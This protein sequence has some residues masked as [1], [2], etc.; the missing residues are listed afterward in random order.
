MCSIKD[1]IACQL[2]AIE[3]LSEG[4]PRIAQLLID[5]RENLVAI[6]FR[7]IIIKFETALDRAPYPN[8]LVQE[9]SKE[10]HFDLK[11]FVK[12]ELPND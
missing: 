11:E 3:E 7:K 8:E 12:K 6:I 9:A 5:W 4:D 2:R 10:L 1:E